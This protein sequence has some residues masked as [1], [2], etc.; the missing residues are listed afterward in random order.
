M[1]FVLL[2]NLKLLPPVATTAVIKKSKCQYGRKTS[3]NM[4]IARKS[5]VATLTMNVIM[6]LIIST[7]L[8]HKK[9]PKQNHITCLFPKNKTKDDQKG[10]NS[11]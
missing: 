1:L 6:L 3:E 10:L 8:K 2:V 4:S 7:F 11:N 9:N 5:G